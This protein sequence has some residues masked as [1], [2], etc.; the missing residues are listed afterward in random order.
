MKARDLPPAAP[1]APPAAARRV[2]EPVEAPGEARAVSLRDILRTVFRRRWPMIGILLGAVFCS[3]AYLM[4]EAS[5]YTASTRVLVRVGREKL[6]SVA[7]PDNQGANFVFSERQENVN[8][9]IE[10][11]SSPAVLERAF[12]ALRAHLDAMAANAPPPPPWRRQLNEMRSAVTGAIRT[13]T[14]PVGQLFGARELT[15]EE[16]LTERL[17]RSLTAAPVRETNVFVAAFHWSDPAFAAFALN[18]LLDAF[19]QEHVRVMSAARGAIDFH[20]GEAA[21]I[22]A[23][24]QAV[25]ADLAR[26]GRENSLT[27]PSAEKQ[28]ILSLISTLEREMAMTQIAE[29]QGRRRIEELRREFAGGA[30]WPS[31]PGIP[32]VALSQ[33]ADLDNRYAELSARRASLL[34]QLRPTAREIQLL[35]AQIAALRQQ[36]LDAL[37]GYLGDRLRADQEAQRATAERL[38]E[39][40]RQLERVQEIESGFLELQGRRDQ[41]LTRNRDL[42]REIERLTL[43]SALDAEQPTSVR[44]LARAAPPLL[45]T[46]P[47]R[48]L[49]VGLAAGFGLLMAIAYAVFAQ[50]FDRSVST[51]DD[52]EQI[53][54]LPVLGRL[55]ELPRR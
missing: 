44:V 33:M 40:R 53:L 31:T 36:K 32:Q 54:A 35:D 41:L 49:V 48:S 39:A 8:D 19:L 38:S 50:F 45:P 12:P 15:E 55:P 9:G 1:R 25:S 24:L 28:V 10:I 37:L 42:Q 11:L 4:I 30:T 23:E 34:N 2:I 3:L 13:V 20:R 5:T 7:T 18:T 26:Y 17:R 21:R 47:R 29:D 51:E 52:L 43:A 14:R 27:D 22:E 46:W 6:T 16:A